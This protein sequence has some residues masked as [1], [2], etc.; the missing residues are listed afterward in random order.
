MWDDR[1]VIVANPHLQPPLWHWPEITWI[2]GFHAILRFMPVTWLANLVICGLSKTSLAYHLSLL[3]LHLLNS[4]LVYHLVLRLLVRFASNEAPREVIAFM[5]S[6]FWAVNGQ[7]VEVL[8]WSAT[9]GHPVATLFALGS[10]HYYLNSMHEGRLQFRPYLWSFILNGL[11]VCAY[12]ISLGYAFCLPFFDRLFFPKEV[13]HRWNPRSPGFGTY[14]TSR[15]LFTLPSI[16]IILATIQARVHPINEFVQFEAPVRASIL[17]RLIHAVYAWAYI[18]S[19][20]FWPFGLTPGHFA[21]IG[22]NF[23]WVY[24]PALLLILGLFVFSWWEKSSI[25][26]AILAISVLLAAPMLGLTENPSTPGDRHSYLPCAFFSLLLAWIASRC[27]PRRPTSNAGWIALGSGLALIALMGLQ[28]HR[29]L[30][31]WENS[32][33]LFTRMEASPEIQ[34]QPALQAHIHSVEANQ[35]I[36]DGQLSAALKIYDELIRFSPGDY[37]YWHQRGLTLHLLG[38][39]PEALQS[40]RTA[41]ALGRSPL[42]LQLI[43]SITAT[44]L[45]AKP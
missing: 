18:Y 34:A 10:F 19:H 21:W 38:R 1:P 12:P 30:R 14:W 23:H 32:Y 28:S 22:L 9:L 15:A 5:A 43:E 31:I 24:L 6:A 20:E 17:L 39:E 11:S 45:P 4:L 7:R 33:T 36:L 26:L 3:I 37:R 42:T 16:A 41:Y 13:S 29:Q 27:W 2:L 35:L 44:T 8:G 25:P 40:L